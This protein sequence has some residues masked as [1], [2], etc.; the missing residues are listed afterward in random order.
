MENVFLTSENAIV[1]LISL[2]KYIRKIHE[3][4]HET[5]ILFF[6]QISFRISTG[7]WMF[8]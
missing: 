8:R 6:N 1:D 4:L 7:T 2:I 3:K 5:L